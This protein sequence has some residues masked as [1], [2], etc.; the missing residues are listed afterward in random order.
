MIRLGKNGGIV[1]GV[2]VVLMTSAAVSWRWVHSKGSVRALGFGDA[3][4]D[5]A[6]GASGDPV[7]SVADIGAP[8]AWSVGARRTYEVTLRSSLLGK[9]DV[10]DSS[11]VLK[12]SA[13]L[14]L[15]AQSADDAR[16]L[17]RANLANLDIVATKPGG[18]EKHLDE[19]LR[20]EA[21][22]PFLVKLRRSGHI[23]S[24]AF[25]RDVKGLGFG[26]VRNMIATL[27][28]V[29][30]E[31]PN[32]DWREWTTEESDQYGIFTAR[33]Q[34]IEPGIFRKTKVQY[35]HVEMEARLQ[36]GQKP[37]HVTIASSATLRRDRQ[38][39]L[40]AAESDEHMVLPLGDAALRSDSHFRLRLTGNDIAQVA[41]L[42]PLKLVETPLFADRPGPNATHADAIR[43]KRELVAGAT[44]QELVTQLTHTPATQENNMARWTVT[45]R[46]TALFDL[47]PEH[48]AE[49]P[50]RLKGKVTPADADMLL[51]S[52]SDAKVP[53]AQATLAALAKDPEVDTRVRS[54]A[55]THLGLQQRP[56]EQTLGE[57]TKLAEDSKDTETR[58]SATLA[59]GSA[60]RQARGDGSQTGAAS[61]QA[62]DYL[63]NALNGAGDRESRIL[64]LEA[65]GN[66][67]DPSSLPAI[68]KALH[69]PDPLIRRTAA[70]A[71]RL[72]PGAEVDRMLAGAL[73]D[74]DGSV[75]TG[76][77]M[78]L[79]N[80]Q[81]TADLVAALAAVIKNDADP[82]IRLQ[83]VALLGR[84]A[85][86]SPEAV[87][88]L[89]WAKDNDPSQDVRKAA[90]AA[91]QPKIATN[92]K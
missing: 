59:L 17:L 2:A 92:R 13:T 66:A 20:A 82:G 71:L 56:T 91:L 23:E 3:A 30:P 46:M 12:G 40:Q 68:E 83:A 81:L 26:L 64:A 36:I 53:E 19:S 14:E 31:G 77:L 16:I 24:I 54:N 27:G 84:R 79:A 42:D 90:A 29:A 44:L 25:E 49:M 63:N 6:P 43:K 48:L 89:Q 76:A 88:V 18:A 58:K 70:G 51:A 80:R 4:S 50:N 32:P 69:D 62:V 1:L 41:A 57:L 21:S 47:E 74:D 67:A 9:A 86:Q 33:Y 85:A 35:S 45:R 37:A 75:R 87:A 5:A 7:T 78:A 61:Q 11:L 22:R 60:A 34:Q 72:I 73:A 38:G 55:A 15:V 8:D 52:V 10:P 65:L 39:I 28:F